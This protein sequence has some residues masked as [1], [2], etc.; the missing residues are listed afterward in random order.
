M[1]LITEFYLYVDIVL[2]VYISFKYPVWWQKLVDSARSGSTA[3]SDGNCVITPGWRLMRAGYRMCFHS[4]VEKKNIGLYKN[5]LFFFFLNFYLF[6]FKL[7]WEE[8][9]KREMLKEA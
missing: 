6:I 5:F 9:K 7:M 4:Y 3:L 2:I 1:L 8:I